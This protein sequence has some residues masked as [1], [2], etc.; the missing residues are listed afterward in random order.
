[1]ETRLP[2]AQTLLRQKEPG[3]SLT[4]IAGQ[5]GFCDSSY[6]STVF[7]RRFGMPPSKMR[8]RAS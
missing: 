2:R 7:T 5:C 3:L 4:E 1:V 8:R 6:F